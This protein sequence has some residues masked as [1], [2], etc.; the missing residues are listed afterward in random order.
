[1][2]GVSAPSDSLAQQ[3]RSSC[4][5]CTDE[6][7]TGSLAVRQLREVWK[8]DF[9]NHGVRTDRAIATLLDRSRVPSEEFPRMSRLSLTMAIKSPFYSLNCCQPAVAYRLFSNSCSPFLEQPTCRVRNCE[10]G[11][12]DEI[13][14]AQPAKTCSRTCVKPRTHV[15]LIWPFGHGEH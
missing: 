6:R 13:T 2:A 3:D 4:I 1:M 15:N 10:S 7:V 12:K 11:R 9:C 5:R 8:S 14:A